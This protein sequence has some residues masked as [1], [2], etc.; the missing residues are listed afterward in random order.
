RRLWEGDTS[1][2]GGDDSRA[3]E[4]LCFLLAFWCRKDAA[5]I[6]RLFRRSGLMRPKG[7]EKRGQQTYGALTIGKACTLVSRVYDGTP[8]ASP[9]DPDAAARPALAPHALG[10]L[11]LCPERPRRTGT[12]KLTVSVR[13]TG[14]GGRGL[15]RLTLS[16]S[17]SNLRDNGKLLQRL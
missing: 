8:G 4:A 16:E 9:P 11:T 2:Y 12:G 15:H 10:D 17:P 6:D 5:Q 13:V 3:D 14:P 1:A 7:D